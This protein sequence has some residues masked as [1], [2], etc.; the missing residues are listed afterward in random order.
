MNKL[1][2]I[3]LLIILNNC[4][5]AITNNHN[6]KYDPNTIYTSTQYLI[7]TNPDLV[8]DEK[9]LIKLNKDLCNTKSHNSIVFKWSINQNVTNKLSKNNIL[10]VD[11]FRSI[12][13]SLIKSNIGELPLQADEVRKFNIILTNLT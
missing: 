1:R 8:R 13:D 10:F 4:C 7:D 11:E 12:I 6:N 3:E 2:I 5:F 9:N